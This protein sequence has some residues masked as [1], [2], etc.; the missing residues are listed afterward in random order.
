MSN[1]RS[2]L[3]WQ[4]HAFEKALPSSELTIVVGYD[5]QRI[6]ADHPNLHFSHLLDWEKNSALDS[7][8]SVIQDFSSPAL[9]MYGDT[10]FHPETLSEL[11]GIEGDAVVAIDS[12]WKRRFSG[13]S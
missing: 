9:V 8:L 1:G 13:R 6:I 7:F 12:V 11:V 5:Y 3:D 4:T 2:I 10:V